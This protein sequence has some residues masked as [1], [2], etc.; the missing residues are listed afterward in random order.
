M[1]L[2][3]KLTLYATLRKTLEDPTGEEEYG[4]IQPKRVNRPRDRLRWLRDEYGGLGGVKVTIP[5]FKG[6]NDPEAYLELEIHDEQIF[7][8]HNYS[9]S[10]KVKLT[11]LEFTSYARIWWNQM[12]KEQIKNGE[13]PI[14]TRKE[15][16]AFLRRRFIPSYYRRE[17]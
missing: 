16:R 13:H 9:E 8:C 11:A 7:S 3:P 5:S 14:I 10:K 15:M 12:R 17:L 2:E 1:V 6:K 4:D